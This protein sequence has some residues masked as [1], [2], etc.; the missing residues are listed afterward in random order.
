[1]FCYIHVQHALCYILCTLYFQETEYLKKFLRDTSDTE[2]CKLRAGNIMSL[3]ESTFGML[4][5]TQE[6]LVS[7]HP[8]S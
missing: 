3:S 6:S 4:A 2:E 7:L 5:C 1:M 8:Q